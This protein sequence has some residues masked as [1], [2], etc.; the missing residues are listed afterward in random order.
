MGFVVETHMWKPYKDRVLATYEFMK[1]LLQ[2]TA[3]NYVEIG[4]IKKQA[5]D[6]VKIQRNYALSWEQ[7]TTRFSMFTFKG[8]EAKY[9]KSNI[10]GLER[11]YYDRNSPQYIKPVKFYNEYKAT[12]SADKP[13]LLA[14]L[15]QAWKEVAERLKL[16]NIHM[17][18]LLRDTMIKAEVYYITDYKT[19]TKA[20]RR[21]LVV[22]SNV[23]VRKDISR[24]FNIMPVII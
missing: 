22:H 5:D 16:N 6:A 8:Y 20:L 18:R 17:K 13:R 11:L 12:A 21:T 14:Y 2:Y 15:P 3:A 7:D 1:S 10:S 9:K 24:T 19:G 23:K 4:S